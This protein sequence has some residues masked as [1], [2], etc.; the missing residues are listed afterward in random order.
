[1]PV[2]PARDRLS[3]RVSFSEIPLQ[4]DFAGKG[5]DIRSSLTQHVDAMM[6]INYSSI[7]SGF[8]AIPLAGYE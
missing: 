4:H 1:M 3:N 5:I 8:Q 2:F 7:R 6:P